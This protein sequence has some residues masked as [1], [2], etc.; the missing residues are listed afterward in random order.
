[1]VSS[2][3]GMRA[4]SGYEIMPRFIEVAVAGVSRR[5]HYHLP[6][7]LESV[8][9]AAGM[10][11]SV[12]FGR[13]ER[14]AYFIRAVEAPDVA[15]TKAIGAILDDGPPLDP[16][17]F[18]FLLWMSDYYRAQ[19][20][21]VIKCAFPPLW[22]TKRPTRRR[23]IAPS[24]PSTSVSLVSL[25]LNT[26]QQE[27]VTTMTAAVGTGKFHA[28]LLHGVTGSGK[29][30]V[31]LRL[32]EAAH[33]AQKGAILL[34]PEIGLTPLLL[35]RFQQRFGETL[36][37]LHSQITPAARNEAWRRIRGGEARLAIGARSALFAPFPN[38]GVIIADEEH[39]P[40]YKQ[41]EGVRYHARDAALVRGQKESAVVVLGSAT[42][43]FESFHNSQTGKYHYLCL[44]ERIEA[45]PLPVVQP[46][47][48]RKQSEWVKPFFTQTLVSA[49]SDCLAAKEQA[50]LFIN[51]RG[52]SPSLL[53][54]DCGHLPGCVHCSVSLAFHHHMKMLV[55]HH[56]GYQTPP[57]TTC[58]VCQGI[59]ILTLG[60]G[61]EQVEA[62]LRAL[63]P[64]ARIARMD[65]DTVR[66]KGTQEQILSAMGEKE[67]DILI[68]TQMI[69]KGHDFP[70]VTLVGVLCADQSF[71]FPDFRAAERTFQLLVQVAGRAGRGTRPGQVLIQ[72]FQPEHESIQ[73]ALLHDYEGFYQREIALRK[74]MRNPPFSRLTLLRLKHKE[75][76]AASEGAAALAAVLREVVSKD[77]G[78]REVQ[79][80]GPA[81]APLVKLRGQ[82]RYQVLLKAPDQKKNARIL[83]A[84]VGWK[85]PKGLQMEVHV[86]PQGFL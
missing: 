45:R 37:A 16:P 56:C 67:I 71:H 66:K 4:P 70:D 40:S 76:A 73:A 38:L 34:V 62:T 81:P 84:I 31:Y 48:L 82:Y 60:L 59:R 63:F 85:G 72:T 52:F 9:L 65:R 18:R 27:A 32:I 19:L 42:P 29:T 80:L 23:K 6:E 69:A 12:P 54:A 2:L 30:E 41:E 79:I 58:T 74:E 24:A 3:P 64:H 55:C 20:G 17:Y 5:F 53:C 21:S 51:R 14:T 25:A 49:I 1:M 86:D 83:D 50:L 35:L 10:R 22:E 57:P 47:D 13:T 68:G 75:E 77:R 26:A 15:Q 78:C 46:V 43:S 33:K 44:P 28:F 8:H 39:D 11:V 36:V 61:T 7:T